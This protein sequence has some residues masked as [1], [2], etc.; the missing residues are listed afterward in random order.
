MN[1]YEQ[2]QEARRERLENA[3]DKLEA[4]AAAVLAVLV[5]SLA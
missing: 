3:A 2:K 5:L 1:A 4:K